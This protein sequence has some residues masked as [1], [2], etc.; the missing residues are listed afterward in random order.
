MTIP[1]T[2]TRTCS[3][4]GENNTNSLRICDACLKRERER[5]ET[6][7]YRNG[8]HTF[9]EPVEVPRI[10]YT[11]TVCTKCMAVRDLVRTKRATSDG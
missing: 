1:V 8:G 6:E 11:I 4:C 7:C 10:G 5:R 2:S 9:S 3:N